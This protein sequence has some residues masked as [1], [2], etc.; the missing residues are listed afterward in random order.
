[1]LGFLLFFMEHIFFQRK[2][3]A[4][5]DILEIEIKIYTTSPKWTKKFWILETVFVI[6]P[7]KA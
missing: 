6:Y 7:S 5:F 4:I 2:K 1:M 3:I